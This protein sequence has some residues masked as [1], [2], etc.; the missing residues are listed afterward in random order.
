MKKFWIL[1]GFDAA[2]GLVALYFFFAGMATARVSSFNIGIW[3]VI[4]GSLAVII[5]GSLWLRRKAQPG[6]AMALLLV[7]AVPGCLAVL[8]FLVLLVTHPRWN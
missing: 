6:I 1:W 4:L 5:G 8:F 3:L 2:I 7:L